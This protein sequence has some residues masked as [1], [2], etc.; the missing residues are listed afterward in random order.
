M[1]S[2]N[3]SRDLSVL[4]Q[5]SLLWVCEEYR[6]PFC[7][8]KQYIDIHGTMDLDDALKSYRRGVMKAGRNKRST[9]FFFD[10]VHYTTFKSACEKLG[11]DYEDAMIYKLSYPQ[12][13]EKEILSDILGRHSK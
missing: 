9:G 10:G 1:N 6:I 7:I 13:S 5:A 3:T 8:L 11:I 4:Y 2:S 12:L